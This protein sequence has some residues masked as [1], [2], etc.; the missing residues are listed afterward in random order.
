MGPPLKLDFT[1]YCHLATLL[2]HVAFTSS[3]PDALPFA[4]I[5]RPIG[6]SAPNEKAAAIAHGSESI[7]ALGGRYY[8]PPATGTVNEN[9]LPLSNSL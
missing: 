7:F 1:H 4:N 9:V 5:I 2:C 3:A 8:P 6:L